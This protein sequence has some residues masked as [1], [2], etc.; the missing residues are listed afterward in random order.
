ME[1]DYKVGDWLTHKQSKEVY[2]ITNYYRSI[3]HTGPDRC[4]LVRRLNKFHTHTVN[5]A[6][7]IIAQD[8]DFSPVAQL[9]YTNNSN[10]AVTNETNE[11]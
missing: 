9:L 3:T 10:K 6:I 4:I 8:F 7:N 2:E 5:Q 1:R 11:E